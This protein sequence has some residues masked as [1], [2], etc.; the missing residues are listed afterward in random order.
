VGLRFDMAKV[1]WK[2]ADATVASVTASD[3]GRGRTIYS[4]GFSYK[5]D[6]HFYGGTFTTGDEYR[7]GDS[8]AVKYDP[9]DPDRNDLVEKE[10]RARWILWAVIAVVVVV[11][12]L[13]VF[14]RSR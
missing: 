11:W 5:V 3:G 10:T 13:L 4:V 2:D 12:F 14:G 9:K 8:V 6:E 7:E 1:D